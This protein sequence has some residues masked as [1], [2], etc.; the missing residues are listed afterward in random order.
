MRGGIMAEI[1]QIECMY[2][3]DYRK[4]FEDIANLM[5]CTELGLE[6]GVNRRIN[7]RAIESDPVLID[8]KLYAYQAKYYDASTKLSDH[9]R[10]L[11]Q[12]IE[13]AASR[14][15]TDLFLYINK[16]MP[17]TDPDTGE[18]AGYIREIEDVARRYSVILQWYT[19]SMIEASLDMP[20]YAHIKNLYFGHGNIKGYYD[21]VVERYESPNTGNT[22]LGEESLAE[23]Y[24]QPSY[25]KSE[26]EMGDVEQLL[27]EFISDG[28]HGVL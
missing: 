9:K 11:I 21:Y 7:Q 8:G 25:Y 14:K 3:K 12:C 10:D 15:V 2:S 23:L 19:L 18:E 4:V 22:L 27:D 5:F 6:K 26:S 13:G 17:D 24:M 1:K 20:K 28:N 16:D